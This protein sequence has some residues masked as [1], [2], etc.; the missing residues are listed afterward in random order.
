MSVLKDLAC[1]S[2]SMD[3]VANILKSPLGHSVGELVRGMRD[4]P[5]IRCEKCTKTPEEI[6]DNVK[7]MQCSVCKTKL[8]F[9]VHYC[10]QCVL[11]DY[12]SS[13]PPQFKMAQNMSEG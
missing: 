8:K 1:G 11:S 4:R 13:F 3:P 7:F 6:G 9:S 12:S 2:T 5:L 10:S